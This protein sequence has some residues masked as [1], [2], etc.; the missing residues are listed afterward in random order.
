MRHD[1]LPG[2]RGFFNASILRVAQ[3][4]FLTEGAFDAFSIIAAGTPIP[5]QFLASMVGVGIG[6]AV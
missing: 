6:H 1:H 3:S 2:H 4:A 5:W